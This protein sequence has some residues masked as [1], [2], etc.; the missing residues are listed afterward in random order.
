MLNNVS[1]IIPSHNNQ[2]HIA[3][4]IDSI[5]AQTVVPHEIIVADDSD[6]ETPCIVERYARE[7]TNQ[8]IL[9][10]LPKCNVSEARNVGLRRATGQ[11]LAFL[12]GDDIWL[13]TKTERQ[14]ELLSKYPDAAGVHCHYFA[15][16]DH[17]DDINRVVPKTA[18]DN[19][20][21]KH[22]ILHQ[23]M[24]A[25]TVMIRRSIAGTLLY[26]ERSGHG[27]DTIHAAEVCMHGSWRLVDDALVGKRV[28]SG[29]VTLSPRHQILNAETRARWCR[30]HSDQIEACLAHEIEDQIWSNLLG[31]FESLYWR[32]ETKPIRDMQQ[33]LSKL[34]PEH[35]S[36]SFLSTRK[37]YPK[38]V[39]LMRDA[40]GRG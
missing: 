18:L 3:A 31:Y 40:L 21:I 25:S 1:V 5:L 9:V 2:E 30:E 10:R 14:I 36:K 28:H 22:I 39:Y 20:N 33:E 6:D 17:I 7:H 8:V 35:W 13:P 27:E 29:Q 26:D 24:P 37:I 11:L 34:C 12:D 32:R 16:H 19:P 38:W 15:F 23:D 4:T